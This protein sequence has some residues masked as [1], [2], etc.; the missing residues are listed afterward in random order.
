[1]LQKTSDMEE[2]LFLCLKLLK[3]EQQKQGR[4]EE[5]AADPQGSQAITQ[6]HSGGGSRARKNHIGMY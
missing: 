6:I 5:T 2:G 1:M 4:N 3:Y